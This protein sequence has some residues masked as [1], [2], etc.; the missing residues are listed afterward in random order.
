[1]IWGC[2]AGNLKGPMVPLIMPT[3]NSR[4]NLTTLENLLPPI[5]DHLYTIWETPIF[6]HDNAPVHT[7]YI[8]QDWL[9]DQDFEVMVW[10][11]YSPDLN[12]SS[13]CGES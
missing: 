9:E 3:V 4:L 11:P 1:M 8:V 7:A 2:F 5:M 13:M 12:R 6:M 10:P